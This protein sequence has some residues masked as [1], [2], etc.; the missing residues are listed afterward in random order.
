MSG[1]P[2]EERNSTGLNFVVELENSSGV[3]SISENWRTDVST[4]LERMVRRLSPDKKSF[5][6]LIMLPPGVDIMSMTGTDTYQNFMQVSGSSDRFTVEHVH[7]K[8][9]SHLHDPSLRNVRDVLGRAA[10]ENEKTTEEIV[11]SGGRS[12]MVHTSEVLSTQEAV[13][14]LAFYYR[15]GVALPGIHRRTVAV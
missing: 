13:D 6:I 3:T 1:A 2:T 7:P 8:D 14:I 15:N 10:P 11:M 5:L 4:A 9:E 12:Q